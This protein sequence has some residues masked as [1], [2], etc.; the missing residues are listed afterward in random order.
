[1][2]KYFTKEHLTKILEKFNTVESRTDNLLLAVMGHKF[3]NEQA[4]EYAHQ[5]FC[6]RVG[7]LRRCIQNV[8]EIIPPDTTQVPSATKL[9]DAAIN[10]Q[11]F[12]ANVY[13][14]TDN[15]AWVWVYE[16]GLAKS[17]DRRQVGLR[18]SQP[19]VRS[20][21]HPEFQK[22]LEG[23]DPWFEYVTEYRDSLGHRIP[24]YIPPGGV[25]PSD[26]AA[27]EELNFRMTT[28]LGGLNVGAYERLQKQQSKLMVFQ[29]LMMHSFNEATSPCTF[30]VQILADFATV[31]EMGQKMLVELRRN[32]MGSSGNNRFARLV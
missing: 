2:A 21:F 20:S 1:L 30:H 10:L 15:L 9:Y 31:E 5:G 26:R 6:R 16:R 29:P 7:T 4:R 19:K 25:R 13:G 22:Y 32:P 11:S 24:L 28:V 27:Y 18:K 8:F 23:M 12:V 17:I 14:C 3:K